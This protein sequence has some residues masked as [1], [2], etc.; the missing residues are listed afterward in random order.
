[1][2]GNPFDNMNTDTLRIVHHPTGA[3]QGYTLFDNVCV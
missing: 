2:L 1:M 3:Q